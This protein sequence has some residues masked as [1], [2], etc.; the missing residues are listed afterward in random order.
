MTGT[1]EGRQARKR[2]ER[3]VAPVSVDVVGPGLLGLGGNEVDHVRGAGV[4]H[5]SE[6]GESKWLRP[7]NRFYLQLVN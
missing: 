1:A 7:V 4:G 6:E 2:N 3:E 5:V